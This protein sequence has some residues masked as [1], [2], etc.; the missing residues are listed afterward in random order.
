MPEGPLGMDSLPAT[1]LGLGVAFLA[2]ILICSRSAERWRGDWKGSSLAL[3]DHGLE[4]HA[5]EYKEKAIA[6]DLLRDKDSVFKAAQG[7]KVQLRKGEG[8]WRFYRTA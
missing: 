3:L 6:G 4:D 1:L 8:D 2:A 5:T 7:I